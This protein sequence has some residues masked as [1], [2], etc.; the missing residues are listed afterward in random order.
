MGLHD[1]L[2]NGAAQMILAEVTMDEDLMDLRRLKLLVVQW[3][4]HQLGL[5]TNKLKNE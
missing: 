1:D 5:W 2:V 4:A 3:A